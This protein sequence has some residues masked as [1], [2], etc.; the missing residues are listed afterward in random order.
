MALRGSIVGSNQT[1][2]D[3]RIKPTAQV[4]IAAIN[5]DEPT[6]S[7]C[8]GNEDP[9]TRHNAF[10]SQEVAGAVCSYHRD[11]LRRRT[12]GHFPQPDGRPPILR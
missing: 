2:F 3:H 10:G 1:D 5:M 4:K 6:R 7:P 11:H 12:D 9:G 8:S